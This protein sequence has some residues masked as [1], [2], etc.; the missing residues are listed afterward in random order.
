MR[1]ENQLIYLALKPDYLFD[2]L[3]GNEWN[4]FI[5]KYENDANAVVEEYNPKKDG[6]VFITTTLYN[7]LKN[8]DLLNL[9]FN[10]GYRTEFH[11]TDFELKS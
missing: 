11:I 4:D 2:V 6:W 3:S 7:I 10:I 5:T 1:I 9:R 8:H